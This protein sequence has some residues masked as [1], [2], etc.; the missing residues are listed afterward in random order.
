MQIYNSLIGPYL[1]YAIDVWGSAD[2]CHINKILILQ[3]RALHFIYFAKLRDHAIPIFLDA[4][5]LPISFLYYENICILMHDVRHE[6]APRNITDLFIDTKS[7][8]SYN[9]RSSASHNFYIKP[10]KLQIQLR[11][12][13]L[14]MRRGGG[15]DGWKFENFHVFFRIPPKISKFFSPSPPSKVDYNLS[16]FKKMSRRSCFVW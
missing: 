5:I 10:S 7:I 3:K 14:F 13:S 2:K 9:T 11:E 15:G 16:L 6:R 12:R 4:G 1:S 8:H